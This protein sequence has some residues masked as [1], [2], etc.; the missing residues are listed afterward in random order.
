MARDL[1]TSRNRSR[2]SARLRSTF[3]LD[4]GRSSETILRSCATREFSAIEKLDST[5]AASARGASISALSLPTTPQN[6]ARRAPLKAT[7]SGR[8]SAGLDRSAAERPR[9]GV[10]A[11]GKCRPVSHQG[12]QCYCSLA[13]DS[14]SAWWNLSSCGWSCDCQVGACQGTSEYVKHP[15]SSSILHSLRD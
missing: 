15:R 13:R 4:H 9:V 10:S 6:G 8:P 5:I 2:S 12:E 1:M 3:S 7:P 14:V 11:P